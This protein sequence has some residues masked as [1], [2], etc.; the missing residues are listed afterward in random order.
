MRIEGHDPNARRFIVGLSQ[1]LKWCQIKVSGRDPDAKSDTID[2]G[3]IK[4]RRVITTPL[5]QLGLV[6]Y[7]LK[8][9]N[10]LLTVFC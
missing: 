10:N 9:F 8:Q 7:L 1:K 4:K 5:S 3:E 2:L 6:Y